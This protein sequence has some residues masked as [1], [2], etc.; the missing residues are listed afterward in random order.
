MGLANVTIREN[1]DLSRLSPQ[2]VTGGSPLVGHPP[3]TSTMAAAELASIAGRLRKLHPHHRD[4]EAYHIEKDVIASDI[5]NL[6]R[7]LAHG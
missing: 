2:G 1:R 4:P 7:K 3:V 5:L 6:A